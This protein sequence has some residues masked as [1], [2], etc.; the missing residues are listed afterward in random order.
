M[1]YEHKKTRPDDKLFAIYGRL[2]NAAY[3]DFIKRLGIDS[4]AVKA[5]EATV[6]DSGGRTFIDLIGGYGTLNLGHNHPRIVQAL[7]SHLSKNGL[8]TKPFITDIQVRFAEKLARVTPGGLICSFITNSGS[9]AVDSAIKLARLSTGKQEIITAIKSFHGYT[10]G[11]LSASGFP[12]FKRGFAPMVPGF[13]HV[14]FG[15]MEALEKTITSDTAAILLEPVQHEAGV[16]LPPEDY[17]SEV[18]SLCNRLDILFIL[19]EVKPGMGKT[20]CMFACEHSGV[21]PD[22][23]LL[24][25]SLGGGQVPIGA[26]IGTERVWK[27]FGLNFAM[28]AS[29]FAGNSL[30]CCAGLTVIRVVEEENMVSE[31][32]RKGDILQAGIKEVA[33]RYPQLLKTVDGVG[34]LFGLVTGHPKKTAEMV[35]G[36]V[37]ENILMAP[38]FGNPAVIMVEPPLVISERQIDLVIRALETVCSRLQIT[39]K[40]SVR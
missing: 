25:K 7:Q 31:C 37:A 35:R 26:V 21:S 36:M 5:K 8:F 39:F 22:I 2:I 11:A 9:E 30:A 15:D 10:Y 17:L 32:R 29:S 14:P 27:K 1:N 4:I 18:R 3:P 38:A 6:T 28:S 40:T 16:V 20:G 33:G 19:D 34:L 24:G 13:V 23:L 12:A